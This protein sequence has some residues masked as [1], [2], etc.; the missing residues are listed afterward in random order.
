[1]ARGKRQDNG[2]RK[3][4]MPKAKLTK[5]NLKEAVL[6]F[7]YLKPYRWTFVTGLL[8]GAPRFTPYRRNRAGELHGT[9]NYFP[10]A[11]YSG[12]P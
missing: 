12:S 2:A 11:C 4:D 8:F 1:M 6:I 7:S 9:R 5:E 3:P 10:D